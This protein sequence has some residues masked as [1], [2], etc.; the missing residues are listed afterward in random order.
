MLRSHTLLSLE[1]FFEVAQWSYCHSFTLHS[2]KLIPLFTRGVFAHKDSTVTL[3]SSTKFKT[4]SQDGLL[5]T[6]S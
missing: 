2:S 4:L 6:L 1:L 5:E 3:S